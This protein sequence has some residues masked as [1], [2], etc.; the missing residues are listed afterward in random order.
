LRFFTV[1]TGDFTVDDDAFTRGTDDKANTATQQDDDGVGSGG[2]N[3][4]LDQQ[5]FMGKDKSEFMMEGSA[6]DIAVF[7]LV[8]CSMILTTRKKNSLGMYS[9]ATH[10]YS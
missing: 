9:S 10:F 4:Q 3:R 6:L 7:Q 2:G 1:G 5:Q 8:R